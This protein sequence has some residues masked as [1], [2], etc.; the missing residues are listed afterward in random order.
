M[1]RPKGSKNKKTLLKEAML[2]EKSNKDNYENNYKDKNK[3]ESKNENKESITFD[4]TTLKVNS[5][6]SPLNITANII[7]PKNSAT[8][9][10]KFPV[11]DRCH[12]EI[13]GTTP[14]SIKLV[15]LLGIADYHRKVNKDSVKLCDDCAKKLNNLIDDFLIDEGKGVETKGYV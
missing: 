14:Y 6:T 10:G 5:D 13:I 7:I 4:S 1:G 8:K 2:R 11:C 12:K 15:Y 3:D 9:P